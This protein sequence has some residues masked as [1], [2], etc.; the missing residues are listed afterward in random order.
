MAET[1]IY[2]FE[3]KNQFLSG[4]IGLTQNTDDHAW[5]NDD[6]VYTFGNDWHVNC[7]PYTYTQ[8]VKLAC[9]NEDM[10][11]VYKPLQRDTLDVHIGESIWIALRMQHIEGFLDP[12]LS[13][14]DK[15]RNKSPCITYNPKNQL[16]KQL[17]SSS[18][19]ISP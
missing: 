5:R 14:H 10:C 9:R 2:V 6:I 7:I 18:V 15:F 1:D 13:L 12:K 16:F 11:C 17:N 4:I 8:L 3:A 19:I